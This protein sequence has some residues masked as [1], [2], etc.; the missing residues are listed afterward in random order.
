MLKIKLCC[1]LRKRTDLSFEEQAGECCLGGADA[2]LLDGSI[3]TGKETAAVGLKIRDITR[4]HKVLFF[5]GGRPDIAAGI[6]ADG[7]H[8]GPDDVGI[9]LARQIIGPGK[10]IG[11]AALTLGHAVSAAEE[12]AGYIMAGPMFS[13]EKAAL[14]VDIIRLIKK[15]VK[16]P[17][18][19][20][21]AINYENIDEILKAGADGIAAGRAVCGA[22]AVKAAAEKFK[23]KILELENNLP[24]EKA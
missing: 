14:G 22:Q 11:Y 16:V 18:I 2:V 7:V 21:G 5:I 6:D 12:G 8:L 3:L 1:V 13:Q 17:V 9:E 19:A 10:I 20:S 24:G 4:K 15:R 23:N